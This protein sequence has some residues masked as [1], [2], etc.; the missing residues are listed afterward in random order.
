MVAVSS[1]AAAA[2]G[3]ALGLTL[4]VLADHFVPDPRRRHPVAVFG[5]AASRAERHLWADARAPGAIYALACTAA[6]AACGAALDRTVAARHPIAAAGV[7]AVC[8][9]TVVGQSGLAREAQG[10]R[11]ALEAGDVRAARA[12]LPR[13]C[14]RDPAALG[15]E[16]LARATIESVAENTSDALVAPLLWGAAFGPAG[17]LGYRAVNTLD[18][19]VGHR[20]PRYGRFGWAA[21]RLDDVA[22]LVPARVTA[23]LMVLA[24][25]CVGGRVGA[26]WR[27]LCRDGGRHPSPNA[28]RC[29]AAAAG[30]LDL[31]LGG[32]NR[33]AHGVEHRHELG[34]GAAPRPVDIARAV[35][36]ARI[37]GAAA[38][39][40]SAGGALIRVR[41]RP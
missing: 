37:V 17:L 31:R 11:A 32:T 4:G 6:A 36:L 16:D 26:A 13:L 21:A 41:R 5:Q 33:Y 1:R 30:A 35:R 20:G 2:T 18:A 39:V 14:G 23:G 8:T 38:T 40:L 24:S 10:L 29:E 9:W 19:M 3:R 34:E 28:G 25:G 15:E 22:N 27:V 7:T 12:R